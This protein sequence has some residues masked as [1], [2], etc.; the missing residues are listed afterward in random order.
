MKKLNFLTKKQYVEISKILDSI[1]LDKRSNH[2]TFAISWLFLIKEHQIIIRNYAYLYKNSLIFFIKLFFKF[3]SNFL[4]IIIYAL[5]IS[6][7]RTNINSYLKK[8]PKTIDVLYFSHL[9]NRNLLEKR[10]DFY[11]DSI[12]SD[13][14][15]QG[16]KAFSFYFNS[17]NYNEKY[18]I[19]KE[20]YHIRNNNFIFFENVGFFNN[21]NFIY[22][23]LKEF[24][25]IINLSFKENDFKK[26]VLLS[27]AVEAISLRTIKNI[28]ISFQVKK[29]LTQ[30]NIKMI[31]TTYEG[32]SY[33][34]LFFYLA[35][36]N[37]IKIITAGYQHNIFTQY[38]HS[39][40]L[41]FNNYYDPDY[42][43]T[44]GKQSYNQYINKFFFDK[45][46]IRILGSIKFHDK[47]NNPK[48]DLENN[49]TIMILP[50]G[51]KSECIKLLNIAISCCLHDSKLKFIFRTHPL[52]DISQ[53]KYLLNS[54]ILKDNIIFSKNSLKDDIL[55]SNFAFFSGSS[56]IIEAVQNGLM[57]LHIN[58]SSD[59][60]TNPFYEIK[61]YIF[62]TNN[63]LDII[64]FIRTN[65]YKN[66]YKIS[67]FKF[68]Q[69]YIKSIYS[70][71]NYNNMSSL[72]RKINE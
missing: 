36:M 32:H 16:L 43:F 7:F 25:R 34:R 21:I 40:L 60:S 65:Q 14:I 19:L 38:Q 53:F 42:I 61:D 70:P 69:N 18:F 71:L 55:V 13:L 3:F 30:S 28:I 50:E 35:K 59:L 12:K 62:S 4:I 58:N 17:I 44:A 29:I 20:K 26:R 22:L 48:I 49:H 57:P 8:L 66:Y 5:K 6:I 9:V 67:N 72:V 52:I 1:L 47:Y 37:N 33:E 51:M 24:L 27:A 10:K 54:K 41:K 46:K 68:I 64:N 15:R 2:T 11:F 31:L 56:A 39:P 23:V 63:Y 45:N